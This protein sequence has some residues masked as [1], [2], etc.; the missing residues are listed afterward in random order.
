MCNDEQVMEALPAPDLGAMLLDLYDEALPAVYG[1]LR[2]RVANDSIAQDLT[3]ETFLSAVSSIQSAITSNVSV[4]WLIGIARHK[5]LDHFRRVAREER[6]L[7]AVASTLAEPD[8]PWNVTL[9]DD[10]T[11]ATLN[12]LGLHHRSALTLRHLDGLSVPEVARVLGRTVH[13]TETL[14]VRARVA[15]RASYEIEQQRSFND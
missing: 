5:L 4:G 11:R 15:F 12:V 9:R 8:D 3:S 7:R 13:A 1:Y 6:N 2:R 10:L 14:L